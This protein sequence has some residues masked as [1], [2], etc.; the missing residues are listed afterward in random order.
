MKELSEISL[1]PPQ[2]HIGVK[3]T[4]LQAR[5]WQDKFWEGRGKKKKK[6]RNLKSKKKGDPLKNMI[7]LEES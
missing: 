5:L 1:P 6:R 3:Q 4:N 2:T 7:Y